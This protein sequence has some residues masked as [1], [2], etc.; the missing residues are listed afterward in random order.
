VS[1]TIHPVMI[2]KSCIVLTRTLT[3]PALLKRI[4]SCNILLAGSLAADRTLARSFRSIYM[5]FEEPNLMLSTSLIYP[6]IDL[7][8]ALAFAT[9]RQRVR[10]V[11][12]MPYSIF[13]SSKSFPELAPVMMKTLSFEL[14]VIVSLNCL[15]MG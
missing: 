5:N 4:S 1:C 8:A 10:T 9:K 6:R 2:S 7:T 3:T 11:V 15:L 12:P 14:N 13:E